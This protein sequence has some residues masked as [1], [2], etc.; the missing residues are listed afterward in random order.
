MVELGVVTLAKIVGTLLLAAG[1]IPFI[2]LFA[3]GAKSE[4]APEETFD[5]D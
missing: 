4:P 1:T 3:P 2:F 5:G